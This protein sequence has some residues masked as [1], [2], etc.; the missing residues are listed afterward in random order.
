MLNEGNRLKLVATPWGGPPGTPSGLGQAGAEARPPS[1]CRFVLAVILAVLIAPAAHAADPDA[2]WKIVHEKC[3]PNQQ[4]QGDPAPCALVDLAAGYAVLKDMRGDT[5]YLLIPTARITGIESPEILAPGAPN[6]WQDSWDARRFFEAKVGHKVPREL[7]GLAI[8]SA[9]ARS[10]NQLHI[11]IDCVRP[12]VRQAILANASKIGPQWTD[13][14]SEIGGHKYR[15]M[16]LEGADLGARNPF[17]LLAD[18]DP[19][20]RAD[21][22]SETLAVIGAVFA[23]G[24]PGFYLL[25]GRAN[26]LRMDFASSETLLDHDCAILKAPAQ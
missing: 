2:L 7:I 1:Q 20:A 5:Q 18:G 25:S 6:Y 16:R 13:I 17:M 21:M 15:A 23:D 22:S 14:D 24:Q 26:I 3:A 4:A 10:Q 12:D 9:H 8:N 11:H 19:A